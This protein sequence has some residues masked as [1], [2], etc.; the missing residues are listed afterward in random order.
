MPK[1]IIPTKSPRSAKK[2]AATLPKFENER[3]EV[4]ESGIHGL[5]LFASKSLR[6]G[7]IVGYYEGPEVVSEEQD[8]DHVLWIFDEDEKREYGINGQNETRFVNHSRKPNA[9]FNGEKLVVLRAI[10]QG[11]EITHDYGEAWSDLG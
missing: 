9:N 11:E 5:G 1:N 8:G 2:K 7:S 3:A 6:K 10:K 4:K